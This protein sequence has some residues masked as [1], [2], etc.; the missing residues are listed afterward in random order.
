[1]YDDV[2]KNNWIYQKGYTDY[3]NSDLYMASLYFTVTTL[4]TVGYGDITAYNFG[5]RGMCILL[6]MIGVFAFSYATGTMSSIISN[7]DSKNIELESKIA[8]LYEIGEDY[9]LDMG[10]FSRI[11]RSL[12]YNH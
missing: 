1:M 4:V 10:T 8:M 2:D 3:E 7:N 6:M 11:M 5:E 9:N 12:K